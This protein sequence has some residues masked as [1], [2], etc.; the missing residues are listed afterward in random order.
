MKHP[1]CLTLSLLQQSKPR[2]VSVVCL[3]V[4]LGVFCTRTHGQE[5]ASFDKA[6]HPG[7]LVH[8]ISTYASQ[9][10]LSGGGVTFAL[11]KLDNEAQRLWTRSFDLT[12]LKALQP[13]QYEATGKIPEYAASGV[14]RLIRAWSGVSD[15]NKGYD[16][17]DT[18]HE[19][20]TVRVINERRDPLPA[21]IDLKLLR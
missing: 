14:Y 15:L 5:L 11:S 12:D 9:V 4:I 16:Y 1:F 8:V 21:L 3:A 19:N 2:R 18:L 20:I 17:P 7:E 6:Y 13:N 10:N